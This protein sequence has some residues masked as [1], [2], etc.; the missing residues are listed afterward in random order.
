MFPSPNFDVEYMCVLSKGEIVLDPPIR[1]L[2]THGSI[3]IGC[4]VDYRYDI[5]ASPLLRLCRLA[6]L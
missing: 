3:V 1:Y 6:R 5:L 2:E 4:P